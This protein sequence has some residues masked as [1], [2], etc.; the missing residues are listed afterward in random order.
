MILDHV[1]YLK[2]SPVINESSTNEVIEILKENWTVID[3]A[4]LM[5]LSRRAERAK[6]EGDLETARKLNKLLTYLV[7]HCGLGNCLEK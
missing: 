5:G 1:C 7:A 6:A 3:G 4:I 2:F